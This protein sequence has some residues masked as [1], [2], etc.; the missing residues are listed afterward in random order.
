M[1]KRKLL[2][3]SS[4]K[5][6]A[7]T[8]MF[9]DHFAASGVFGL[10]S[11]SDYNDTIYTIL[12]IIGRLAFPIFCFSVAE[13]FHHAHDKYK[14]LL[15]L[16]VFALI[17]EI[18]FDLAFN[19]AVPITTSKSVFDFSD[20]NVFFTLALGL[21]AII[22]FDM[23]KDKKELYQRIPGFLSVPVIGYFADKLKTDYGFMGV[24]M[25]FCFYY[26]RG[27]FLGIS[28]STFVIN[29]LMVNIDVYYL[30]TESN[31]PFINFVQ[32]F[33]VLPLIFIYIYNGERGLNLKYIFYWFYP[34]HLILL[35]CI[36]FFLINSSGI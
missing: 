1:T 33:A 29:I 21:L 6:I 31:P 12:R 27:N 19:L 25:I 17:S 28:I 23:F 13:G 14:Y 32:L 22:V 7:I 11:N 16:S 10:L 5:I 4:L 34:V 8:A 36:K 20:Q 15:R 26:F 9:I 2:T 3:S 18:P 35:F 24:L 30:F